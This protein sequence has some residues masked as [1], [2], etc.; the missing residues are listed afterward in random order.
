[1]AALWKSVKQAL[2]A[3][4]I[5]KC[6]SLDS[7][8]GGAGFQNLALKPVYV[9][10]ENLFSIFMTVSANIVRQRALDFLPGDLLNICQTRE[11]A[12]DGH[13]SSQDR[14]LKSIILYPL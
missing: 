6:H 2:V 5:F 10:W 4:F 12:E 1:M 11:V 7:H 9:W 14:C 8:E 13:V 3:G